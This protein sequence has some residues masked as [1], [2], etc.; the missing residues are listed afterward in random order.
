MEYNF[1]IDVKNVPSIAGWMTLRVYLDGNY[2]MGCGGALRDTDLL[3][4]T[5]KFIETGEGRFALRL[6]FDDDDAVDDRSFVH[7]TWNA[8]NGSLS[9][10]VFAH[11]EL[12][13]LTAEFK[14][15]KSA[16][17]DAFRGHL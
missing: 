2:I 3:D 1:T 13:R 8:E 7:I 9:F 15:S 5:Y 17:Q 6:N 12:E 14:M 16:V 4:E 10:E 11:D